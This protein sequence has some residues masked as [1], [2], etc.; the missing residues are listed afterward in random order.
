[1]RSLAEQGHT[2]RTLHY[3][4]GRDQLRVERFESEGLQNKASR[5]RAARSSTIAHWFQDAVA[6]GDTLVM[7]YLSAAALGPVPDASPLIPKE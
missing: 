1:M 3:N 2:I 7:E 5:E 4:L 6:N